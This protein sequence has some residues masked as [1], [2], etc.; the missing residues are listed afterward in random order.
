MKTILICA[1]VGV[2]I[3]GALKMSGGGDSKSMDNCRTM[4]TEHVAKNNLGN[5]F[6]FRSLNHDDYC[7]C[8]IDGRN[9]PDP[10]VVS[11]SCMMEH[12]R[13]GVMELCE[14]ELLPKLRAQANMGMDCACYYEDSMAAVTRLI[15]QGNANISPEQEKIQAEATLRKCAMP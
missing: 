15:G 9:E 4:I 6:V 8:L 5:N 10:K 1:L 12:A 7:R 2:L 11:A 3:F 13:V 14:K